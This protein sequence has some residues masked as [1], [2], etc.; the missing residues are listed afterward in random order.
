MSS[1][2]RKILLIDDE[3]SIC[4]FTKFNLESMGKYEVT[5]ALSGEEGLKKVK[6]TTFDLVI[7]D[8][9]M[10]GMN[11]EQVIEELKKKNPDLPVLLF[12]IYHDDQS[13]VTPML[14]SKADGLLT[15][16]IDFE[17]FNETIERVLE[18]FNKK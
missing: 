2:K 16:P 6:E 9:R 4:R 5:T 12:S 8:F 11:G 15:K 3:E 18:K 14:K 7:T 13:T 10:G 1:K 17:K